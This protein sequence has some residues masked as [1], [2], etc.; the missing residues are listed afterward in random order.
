LNLILL[1][2]TEVTCDGLV[3]LSGPRAAHLLRVLKVTPG[4]PV[5]VGVL[6]GA[7]GVGTVPRRPA[8]L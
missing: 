3:R 5:R 4:Q 8:E 7:T 2:A 6:D 1:A